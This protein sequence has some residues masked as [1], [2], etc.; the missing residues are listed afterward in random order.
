MDAPKENE[1]DKDTAHFLLHY[2]FVHYSLPPILLRLLSVAVYLKWTDCANLREELSILSNYQPSPIPLEENA[3]LLVKRCLRHI[4]TCVEHRMANEVNPI[5]FIDLFP[6]QGI[7]NIRSVNRRLRDF[8]SLCVLPQW[9]EFNETD[10]SSAM[11]QILLDKL[12]RSVNEWAD[13]FLVWEC[14]IK[15]GKE[16]EVCIVFNQLTHALLTHSHASNIFFQQFHIN[17]IKESLEAIDGKITQFI[18]LLLTSYTSEMRERKSS[19][20][21][22]KFSQ[23]TMRLF[24]ALH[25]LE[26]LGLNNG[27]RDTWREKEILFKDCPLYWSTTWSALSREMLIRCRSLDDSSLSD[28]HL[29]S[30]LYSFLCIQKAISDD[31]SRLQLTVLHNQ[32]LVTLR[33]VSIYCDNLTSY[34][35][36]LLQFASREG[37]SKSREFRTLRAVNGVE[38]SMNFMKENWRRF[39]LVEG[40]EKNEEGRTIVETAEKMVENTIEKVTHSRDS[41]LSALLGIRCREGLDRITHK[42]LMDQKEFKSTLAAYMRE[43]SEEERLDEIA[44]EVD[45]ISSEGVEGLESSLVS[46]LLHLSF[47]HISSRISSLL[48]FNHSEDYY[49]FIYEGLQMSGEVLG[50]TQCDSSLFRR[51]HYHSQPTRDLIGQFY[52]FLAD[53]SNQDT[54]S[55]NFIKMRTSAS[56]VSDGLISLSL[57]VTSTSGLFH[58]L[59]PMCSHTPFLRVSLLPLYLFDPPYSS[60]LPLKSLFRKSTDLKRRHSFRMLISPDVFYTH[61]SVVAISLIEKDYLSIERV[62]GSH[63]ILLSQ[64]AVSHGFSDDLS[65]FRTIPFSVPPPL[66]SIPIFAALKS[67]SSNDRL[68]KEFVRSETRKTLK[69]SLRSSHIFITQSLST[70][71]LP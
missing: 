3:Q 66:N 34:S 31:L 68:A 64:I 54:S 48:R 14:S 4:R 51:L 19:D 10:P 5:P 6:P 37:E 25:R 28:G 59:S 35:N 53:S 58:P 47:A 29:P 55:L 49:R 69:K 23:V 67:R 61:G 27:K 15:E 62:I 16:K 38:Q 30:S 43:L 2:P 26:E 44:R 50:I 12:I 56:F 33:V 45:R 40:M 21:V 36:H 65:Q 20:D 57:H 7:D 9:E 17:Y 1:E 71:S 18:S 60:E 46:P 39:S 32:M 42:L 13:E 63:F 52:A 11:R 8:M 24:E 22:T 41:L 70:L